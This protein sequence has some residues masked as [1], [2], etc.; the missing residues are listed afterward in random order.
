LGPTWNTCVGVII[1]CIEDEI[2]GQ[3]PANDEFLQKRFNIIIAELSPIRLLHLQG[4]GQRRDL[5]EVKV[6]AH[7][8]NVVG[9]GLIAV[10]VLVFQFLGEEGPETFLGMGCPTTE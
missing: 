1:G 7:A 3:L 8:G 4:Q 6:G 10:F 9:L 5:T 2:H